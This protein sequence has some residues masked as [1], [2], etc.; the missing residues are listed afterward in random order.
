MKGTAV[1]EEER[2][3][4]VW[5]ISY[6]SALG[7]WMDRNKNFLEL[8]GDKFD[9]SRHL[10]GIRYFRFLGIAHFFAIHLASVSFLF[11]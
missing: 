11:V 10:Y 2:M 6:G 4:W 9:T 5:E 7:H 3:D 8:E 1:L